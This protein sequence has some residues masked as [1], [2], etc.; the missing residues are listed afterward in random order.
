M[1]CGL[2]VIATDVGG[3][4]EVVCRQELGTIVPFGDHAGLRDAL[5]A[6]L[7]E[8]WNRKQIRA[9]A[10]DNAWDARIECLVEEF[11]ALLTTGMAANVATAKASVE[12]D[13][14]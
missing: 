10:V 1:A 11:M 7:S 12:S 4:A 5:Q 2:P 3:N 8:S 13:L 6:A 9:Y 14:Q